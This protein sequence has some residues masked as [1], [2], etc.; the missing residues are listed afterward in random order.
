MFGFNLEKKTSNLKK[1]CL[2]CGVVCVALL[3]LDHISCLSEV[4]RK[5]P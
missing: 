1:K 3:D 2:G 5:V 4:H